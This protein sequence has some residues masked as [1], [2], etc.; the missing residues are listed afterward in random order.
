MTR[1]FRFPWRTKRDI[2]EDVDAELRFHLD[3]R[4]EELVARGLAPDVA[5]RQ[6]LQEFGDVDDARRYMRT[7]DT[8]TE[9]TRR[10][11]GS[12]D[13]LAQDLGY[14]IRAL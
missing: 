1:S 10:R 5:R 6:A 9:G 13:D 12:L 14:A 8:R 4:A 11:R 7:M 3:A 2:R